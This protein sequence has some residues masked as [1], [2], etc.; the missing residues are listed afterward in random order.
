VG[1]SR[2]AHACAYGFDVRAI[3]FH[4]EYLVTALL[5][6]GGLEAQAPGVGAEI[7]LGVLTAVAQ[8]RKI[9]QVTL[10]IEGEVLLDG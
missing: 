2:D 4:R 1:A 8:L 9:G 3:D 6:A 7:S 5:A 10:A